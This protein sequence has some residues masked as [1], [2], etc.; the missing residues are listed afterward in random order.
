M[1]EKTK[2]DV[3]RALHWSPA[4]IRKI[5]ACPDGTND[6]IRSFDLIPYLQISPRLLDVP[7]DFFI[8]DT[9]DGAHAALME[10]LEPLLDDSEARKDEIMSLIS[11]YERTRIPS[12]IP[13]STQERKIYDDAMIFCAVTVNQAL[14][15]EGFLEWFISRQKHLTEEL[16]IDEQIWGM[17]GAS[18]QHSKARR[19]HEERLP[20]SLIS[21]RETPGG[22]RLDRNVSA[23]N[24]THDEPIG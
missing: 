19:V 1:S 6:V 7:E 14:E 9:P 4:Y 2:Q 16:L 13:L 22:Y 17:D 8:P 15:P 10:K 24:V 3:A 5:E 23:R 18:R 21:E 12:Y 11:A 20:S